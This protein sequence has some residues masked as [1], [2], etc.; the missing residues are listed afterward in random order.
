MAIALLVIEVLGHWV[1]FALGFFL[2]FLG[3]TDTPPD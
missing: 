2:F 3:S 1:S